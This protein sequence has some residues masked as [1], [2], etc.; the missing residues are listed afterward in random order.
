[1]RYK[2]FQNAN[3]D[4]SVLAVGTWALGNFGYGDAVS[5][6][7]LIRKGVTPRLRKW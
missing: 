5:Y 2:H 7:H 6:T 1:M 3:V 4:A